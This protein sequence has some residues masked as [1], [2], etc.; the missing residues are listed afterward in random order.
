[1][2]YE[3][4]PLR[5]PNLQTAKWQ[6]IVLKERSCRGFSCEWKWTQSH[7]RPENTTL[8]QR[9]ACREVAGDALLPA[10][11]CQG[12][13]L[14][15]RSPGSRTK[16]VGKLDGW[17]VRG[18]LK[19]FPEKEDSDLRCR[20]EVFKETELSAGVAAYCNYSS[21]TIRKVKCINSA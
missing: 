1:M 18:F 12:T 8:C 4:D 11:E 5:F 19:M 21:F 20:T 14:A 16:T 10:R 13:G 9:R 6:P 17:S 15:V 7:S 2:N 3:F